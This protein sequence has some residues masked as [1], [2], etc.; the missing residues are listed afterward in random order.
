MINEQMNNQDLRKDIL[1]LEEQ[2][3]IKKKQL[4]LNRLETISG[5][6]FAKSCI[7]HVEIN[8]SSSDNTWNISYNHITDMYNSNDYTYTEDS[9][10][11]ENEDIGH[12]E[13]VISFGK[14]SKYFI[15]GGVKLTIYRNTAGELRVINPDYEFDIDLDEQRQLVQTYADNPNLPEWLAIKVF[16]YLSDN[17]WDDQSLINHLSTV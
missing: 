12:K 9:E 15:R 2:I 10:T 3:N 13:T 7:S 5:M 6:S 11:E 16:L 8:L 17:K 1:Q 14:N 4:F